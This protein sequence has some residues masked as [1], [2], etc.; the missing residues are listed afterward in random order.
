MKTL[1]PFPGSVIFAWCAF[2]LAGFARGEDTAFWIWGKRPAIPP[3]QREE[4]LRQGTRTLYRQAATVDG[5]NLPEATMARLAEFAADAKDFTVVPVIRVESRDVPT[6]DYF[7]KLRAAL[8]VLQSERLQIDFDCPD[9]LLGDYA[10]LL[11]ELRSTWPRLGITALAHWP[12]VKDFPELA[13]SSGEICPMFYDLQRDPTGVSA[14]TPPPPLLDPAQVLPILERWKECPAPWRAGLPAFT[15]VTVFDKTGLSRGQIFGW[16]WP[17]V[18]F[19]QQLR[20]AKAGALGVQLLR[21]AAPTRI[22]R[23]ALEKDEWLAVRQTDPE[24]LATCRSAAAKAGA[25]GI[26]FF[27]LPDAEDDSTISLRSLA[28]GDG[29]APKMHAWIS[30]GALVL[31]NRGA[32][33]LAPRLAGERHDRD[34]GHT[35]EVDAPAAYFREAEPG[36]FHRVTA[37]VS[38]ES[39]PRIAPVH[40]ATRITFWVSHLDAGASLRSGLFQLAPHADARRIR[41]RFG[42]GEWQ[43]LT[44]P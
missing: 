1:P 20:S 9:R 26:V 21:V 22:A 11:R 5:K 2:V 24:A 6:A 33:D 23:R 35:L 36:D 10:A 17:E 8:P 28:A 40:A 14:E 43:P 25:I 27:R 19:N 12:L 31:E 4:L 3:A 18:V 29:Q 32:A 44:S 7:R 13:R 15:R 42:G 16:E 41:W 39:E 34:R 37:H 30:G 38:P